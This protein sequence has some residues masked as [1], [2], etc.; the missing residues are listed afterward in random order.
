MLM[1]V[2]K[3][4]SCSFASRAGAVTYAANFHGGDWVQQNSIRL[5]NLGVCDEQEDHNRLRTPRSAT[6]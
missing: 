6:F 5:E 3:R 1:E 4:N 2:K